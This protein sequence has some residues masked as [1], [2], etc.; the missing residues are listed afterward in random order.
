[1]NVTLET[2]TTKLRMIVP[3]VDN[4]YCTASHAMMTISHSD[5][6][7]A[8]DYYKVTA[9]TVDVFDHCPEVEESISSLIVAR[10]N[11]HTWKAL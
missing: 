11:G 5:L 9:I 3:I 1:M 6:Q 8:I 7:K 10:R 4:V 2:Y